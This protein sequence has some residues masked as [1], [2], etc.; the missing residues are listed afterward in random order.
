MVDR[1]SDIEFI[2]LDVLRRHRGGVGGGYH[3]PGASFRPAIPPPVGGHHERPVGDLP[4]GGIDDHA[5]A[6]FRHQPEERHARLGRD[7]IA[8]GAS[9]VDQN[10]GGETGAAGNLDMP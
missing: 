7:L 5:G 4:G 1:D 3:Q 10:R 8:P 2:G 6:P 9:G